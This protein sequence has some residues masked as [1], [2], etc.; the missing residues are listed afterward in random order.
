MNNKKL[1][2]Y[3]KSLTMKDSDSACNDAAELD[4]VII[5]AVNEVTKNRKFSRYC[6]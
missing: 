5:D 4:E 1:I 2:Q 3:Y 6:V